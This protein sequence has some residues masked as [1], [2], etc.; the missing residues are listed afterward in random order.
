MQYIASKSA[1]ATKLC[2]TECFWSCFFFKNVI[3][4][5]FFKNAIW[6]CFD[7]LCYH[8]ALVD[9]IVVGPR[10]R[11][12]CSRFIWYQQRC[13]FLQVDILCGGKPVSPGMTLHDLAGCWLNKGQKGRVRSSVGTPADG[14][15]AK[16]FYGR[17]GSS[18]PE[19]ENNQDWSR[20]SSSFLKQR[21]GISFIGALDCSEHLSMFIDVSVTA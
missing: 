3:W 12:F 17:S 1:I 6:A 18:K 4:A 2:I 10:Q 7:K 11:P 16:V 8:L 9:D 15:I 19:T 5:V 14:F 21:R 20:A 13:L